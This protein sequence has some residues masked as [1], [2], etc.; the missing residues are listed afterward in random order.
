MLTFDDYKSKIS[1]IQVLED[2]GYRQDKADGKV[3]PVFKL[4]DAHGNKIDEVIVKNP[5]GA[6]EYYFD[7]N[8]KGGDLIQFLK[9]HINDFPQFSH[10]NLFVH[11]NKILSHYANVTYV[12][13]ASPSVSTKASSF[14]ITRYDVQKP[15]LKDLNYLTISRS[16][17]PAT[18]EK[19]LPF[20]LR[21]R[22]KNLNTDFYNIAFPY[23]NPLDK[24]KKTTNFETRNYNYK[25]MAAGGDKTNSLWV[26]DFS[27]SP[28]L[29][30]SIYFAESALD[31]MSYYELYHNKVDFSNAV[32]CSI[33]GYISNKQIEN[34]LA[35]YPNAQ[36]HTIF[37]NDL[38]GHL[39]DIKVHSIISKKNIEIID[40]KDTVKFKIWNDREFSLPKGE[41]SLD[42]FRRNANYKVPL[43]V[44]KADGAKDF[45]EIL[46]NKNEK[47]NKGLH[48]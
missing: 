41:V 10:P 35:A 1:I 26:A 33:G 4:R 12:P 36:V 43:L 11:L 30:T 9:Q 5:R 42:S 28:V 48:L 19:F 27:P 45:N 38:N 34:A 24:E 14:D 37:D 31:A 8:H 23:H 44:H 13:Q 6:N 18:I 15:E 16:I 7:R 17:S 47:L 46:M 22:D 40:N 20:I 32:L 21:V 3:S 2:L 29:A 25:G 39:Y